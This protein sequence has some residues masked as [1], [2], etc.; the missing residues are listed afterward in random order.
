MSLCPAH[1]PCRPG[2]SAVSSGEDP[3][4]AAPVT[5]AQTVMM[6][7]ARTC[8]SSA[9]T[10]STQPKCTLQSQPLTATGTWKGKR[11][12]KAVTSPGSKDKDILLGVQRAH[13]AASPSELRQHISMHG[14]RILP[15][16]PANTGCTVVCPGMAATRPSRGPA[17]CPCRHRGVQ[18]IDEWGA[19]GHPCMQG[20][21]QPGTAHHSQ[22]PVAGRPAVSTATGFSITRNSTC[23][24]SSTRDFQQ[25]PTHHHE[26]P[27]LAAREQ[28]GPRNQSCKLPRCWPGQCLPCL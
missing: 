25:Q 9:N 21:P 12:P 5:E 27:P 10:P 17:S 16:L 14:V 3:S 20:P 19:P 13:P 24:A 18:D 6:G 22:L 1:Q 28:A 15:A 8:C 4:W 23:L 26:Q 2:C 11:A 7:S